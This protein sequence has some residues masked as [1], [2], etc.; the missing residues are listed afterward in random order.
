MAVT[1]NDKVDK[2]HTHLEIHALCDGGY[3][4]REGQ[5]D[6]REDGNDERRWCV[7]WERAAFSTL[8]EA[9]AWVEAQMTNKSPAIKGRAR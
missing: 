1:L 4:V 3:V 2:P 8:K 7:R 9:V 6:Y 5:Y